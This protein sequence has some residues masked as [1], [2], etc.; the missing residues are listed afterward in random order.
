[1][2]HIR[3][4]VAEALLK[5]WHQQFTKSE[6]KTSEHSPECISLIMASEHEEDTQNTETT[7]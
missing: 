7:R 5:G 4:W 1:M 6:K 3:T 2:G